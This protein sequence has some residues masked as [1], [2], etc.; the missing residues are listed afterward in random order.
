MLLKPSETWAVRCWAMNL[1][2]RNRNAPGLQPRS[3]PRPQR[4]VEEPPRRSRFSNAIPQGSRVVGWREARPPYQNHEDPEGTP[5][6]GADPE[7][8]RKKQMLQK[9]NEK[10]LHTKA[11]IAIKSVNA[12]V[13]PVPADLQESRA[14]ADSCALSAP[15]NSQASSVPGGSHGKQ[16]KMCKDGPL[17][18]RVREILLQH[19]FSLYS[20]VKT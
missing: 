11:S 19:Q 12:H 16:M 3:E 7:L 14:P 4:G 20:K 10:I 8:L 18:D 17:R 15:G 5:F 2:Y 13:P 6:A 9:L 1:Q